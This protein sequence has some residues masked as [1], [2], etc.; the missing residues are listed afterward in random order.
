V[1]RQ[2]PEVFADMDVKPWNPW[3]E[4]ESAL[5]EGRSLLAAAFEKLRRSV[6]GRPLSFVPPTDI[7]DVDGEYQLH[8]ALPGL[9][10]EDIDVTLE[11]VILI[12]RGERECPYAPDRVVVL[13]QQWSYGYFERRVQL[14]GLVDPESI[15]AGFENGVLTIRIPKPGES[16]GG[17]VR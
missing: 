9:L 4:V 6:P 17:E 11:G 15:R 5:A 13:E 16:L 8:L 3:Q 10:E 1:W 12:I 2:I 7:V 14:P